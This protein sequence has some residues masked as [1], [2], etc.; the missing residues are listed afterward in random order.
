MLKKK[1]MKI[2]QKKKLNIIIKNKINF[3]Y[4]LLYYL[5]KKLIINN[6]IKI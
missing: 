6:S 2:L 5:F 3:K 4:F 1:N